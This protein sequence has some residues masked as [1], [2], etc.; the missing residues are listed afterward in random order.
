MSNPSQPQK[1]LEDRLKENL[2]W[3]SLGLIFFT[4]ISTTA[5]LKFLLDWTGQTIVNADGIENPMI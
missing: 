5:L 3:F 1:S 4:A 2:V